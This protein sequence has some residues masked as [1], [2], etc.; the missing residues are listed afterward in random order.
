M[1][2][3]PGPLK[4]ALSLKGFGENHVRLPLVSVRRTTQQAITEALG[5]LGG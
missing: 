5:Q 4:Y 3:N 2:T 1:E